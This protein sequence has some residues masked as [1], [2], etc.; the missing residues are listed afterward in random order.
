MSEIDPNNV[1]TVLI[2]CEL[3]IEILESTV[4]EDST[5]TEEL[6]SQINE[7]SGSLVR[8]APVPLEPIQAEYEVA[9]GQESAFT[10]DFADPI[11]LQNK[12]NETFPDE[13]VQKG[14]EI[15]VSDNDMPSV[16]LIEDIDYKKGVGFCSITFKIDGSEAE[17]LFGSIGADFKEG[18]SYQ[19]KES[20]VSVYVDVKD[21]SDGGLTSVF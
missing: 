6:P 18:E 5:V 12:A 8:D 4:T 11:V 10:F 1:H 3:S 21:L 13:M 15:K 2:D 20:K 16:I 7:I 9:W 17:N 19:E 14:L